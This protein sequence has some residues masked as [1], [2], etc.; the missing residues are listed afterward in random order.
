[1]TPRFAFD[2]I[3]N[4]VARNLD[5]RLA[6]GMIGPSIQNVIRFRRCANLSREVQTH[7]VD[8]VSA[9]LRAIE[10]EVDEHYKT[11]DLMELPFGQAT[12]YFMSA[13]EDKEVHRFLNERQFAIHH[14]AEVADRFVTL[15]RDPFRWLATC[16]KGGNPKLSVDQRYY[17]ASVELLD[18][19]ENYRPFVTAFS[20]ASQGYTELRIDDTTLSST[21]DF[22]RESQ[23]EAYDRLVKPSEVTQSMVRG[24]IVEVVSPSVRVRGSSFSY[25][26]NRRVVSEAMAIFEPVLDAKVLA[27]G[28][29]A[30]LPL[31]RPGFQ[32]NNNVFDRHSIPALCCQNCCG[33][34]RMRRP[35]IRERHISDSPR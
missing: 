5:G 13:C 29:L 30:I 11:N 28:A 2:N 7:V 31:L 33:F 6:L 23:Y 9:E 12:W 21:H 35:G 25:D 26:L 8:P 20:Y 3:F 1:M 18:L 14:A 15:L 19:A 34:A 27:S 17:Q 32:A 24:D 16:G 4:E 22:Q 10:K